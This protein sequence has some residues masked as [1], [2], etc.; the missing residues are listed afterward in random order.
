MTESA[1][2]LNQQELET[3]KGKDIGIGVI[4][5]AP[6]YHNRELRALVVMDGGALLVVELKVTQLESE[7]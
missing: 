1:R 4:L 7:G 6:L 5:D 2:I 3:L